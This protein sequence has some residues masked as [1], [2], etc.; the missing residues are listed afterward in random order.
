MLKRLIIWL[1]GEPAQPSLPRV[2]VVRSFTYKLNVGNYESRDFF[3]SQKITCEAAQA[4]A[5]SAMLAEWCEEQVLAQVKDYL[6]RRDEQAARN[7]KG[8]A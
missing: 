4:D 6:R 8:A 2:E 7:R 3:A 1:I 5:A